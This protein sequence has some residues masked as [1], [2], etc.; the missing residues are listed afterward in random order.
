MI[1][2]KSLVNVGEGFPG[3]S[4]QHYILKYSKVHGAIYAV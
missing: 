2:K 3:G 1:D 4:G